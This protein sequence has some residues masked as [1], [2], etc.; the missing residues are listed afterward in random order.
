VNN[1]LESITIPPKSGGTPKG[2]IVLLHGWGA[3]ASDLASLASL[4]NLPD[5]LF[6][7][8][9]APYP[10]PYSSSGRA[11]YDLRNESFYQGLEDS[12]TILIDWLLSLEENTGVSIERSLLGG[13]SQGGAMTLDIG[14]KLPFAGLISMSGYLHPDAAL[15]EKTSVEKT[16]VEKTSDDNIQA[17]TI[18]PPTLIVHGRQDA[19]VPITAAVNARDNLISQGVVVKYQEFDMGHEIRPEVLNLVEKFIEEIFPKN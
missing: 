1:I 5:F 10:Y 19:V 16:S 18:A 13:F 12:R 11:W 9:N 4:L 17:T 15:V 6:I 14:L 7:F 3:D 8:P 2:L